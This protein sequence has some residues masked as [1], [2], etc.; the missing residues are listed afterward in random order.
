MVV[1]V[2]VQAA[3]ICRPNFPI[4]HDLVILVVNL[5]TR[6][7]AQIPT[8]KLVV[9]VPTSVQ[10]FVFLRQELTHCEALVRRVLHGQ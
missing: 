7:G 3:P 8:Q 9:F 4:E 5:A 10:A 2:S 1:F 6:V